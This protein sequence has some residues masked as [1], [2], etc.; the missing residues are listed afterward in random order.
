MFRGRSSLNPDCFLYFLDCPFLLFYPI[1]IFSSN[2]PSR[3]FEPSIF[4]EVR[5]VAEIRVL[6]FFFNF[7]LLSAIS[8]EF[9][10]NLCTFHFVPP[11][12]LDKPI[13][14]HSSIGKPLYKFLIF[15][16]EYL[17]GYFVSFFEMRQ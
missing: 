3:F 17:T 8:I 14:S 11:L 9:L 5:C 6:L 13:F 12:Y 4:S 7:C 10:P 2:M 1:Y 16:I 15:S